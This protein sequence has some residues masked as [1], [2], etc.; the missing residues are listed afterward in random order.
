M[1][2]SLFVADTKNDLRGYY[3]HLRKNLQLLLHREY[4]ETIYQHLTQSDEF[5]NAEVIM[6][7]VSTGSEV[8]T[9]GAIR[10]MLSMGKRIVV[11]YCIPKSG[12]LGVAEIHDIEKDLLPGEYNIFE[13]VP[14][15]RD[16]SLKGEVQLVICP[17]VAF[18]NDGRR[19]GRGKAY[20]DRFLG[21][22]KGTIPIFGIAFNCQISKTAL[23][24]DSHDIT[25]DQVITENGLCMTHCGMLAKTKT[26]GMD[27]AG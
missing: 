14:V 26:F 1:D 4:S 18:D 12:D 2:Q 20:Y 16:S 5:K 21:E 8:S 10:N 22:I 17:G 25:M 19:L 11:P 24:H 6:I 15:L 13:P 9:F 23:P 3:I 7:Y 27:L